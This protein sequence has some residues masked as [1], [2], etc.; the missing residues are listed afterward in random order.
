VRLLTTALIILVGVAVLGPSP[1]TGQ[2]RPDRPLRVAVIQSGQAF[3]PVS[4][5]SIGG[6]VIV[7]GRCYGLY[8]IRDE[9]GS[10]LAFGAPNGIPPGQIVR[11]STPAG[12]KTKGR[13]FYWVPLHSS[14]ALIP[15][16][17]IKPVGVRVQTAG[18]QTVFVLLGVPAPVTITFKTDLTN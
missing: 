12:A 18:A 2:E 4:T 9:R 13:I 15:I 7:R 6:I 17:T 14:V 1:A 8:L 10:F 3:C 11:L 16:H 5:L